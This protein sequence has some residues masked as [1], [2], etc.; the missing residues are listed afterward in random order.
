[1]SKA[2]MLLVASA[3][4][5]SLSLPSALMAFQSGTV[6]YSAVE[7]VNH[8]SSEMV[9]YQLTLATGELSDNLLR[10]PVRANG[11][12][13]R[14]GTVAR[15]GSEDCTLETYVVFADNTEL[16][17][18]LDY[19]GTAYVNASGEALWADAASN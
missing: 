7:V 4:A 14:L 9:S 15:N 17:G 2:R 18:K 12:K 6:S 5:I 3:A 13:G 10:R 1:M 19:C 8:H 16:T 11:G